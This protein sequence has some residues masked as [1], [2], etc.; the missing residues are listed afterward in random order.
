MAI[1]G[2]SEETKYLID[3]C[4]II[5]QNT[6]DRFPRKV[7]PSLWDK[8]GELIAKHIIIVCKTTYDEIQDSDLK[9]WL[10]Q[11]KY[12]SIGADQETEDNVGIINNVNPQI[13]TSKR[14]LSEADIV[15]IATAMQYGLTIITE[16]SKLSDKKIPAICKKHEVKSINIIDLCIEKNWKF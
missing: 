9:T 1:L 16:E 7:F 15:L 14:R 5:N 8:I 12:Y 3:A 13:Q 10:K 6:R 11:N 4:S 2:L